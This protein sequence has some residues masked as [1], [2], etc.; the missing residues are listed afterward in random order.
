MVH[1]VEEAVDLRAQLAAGERVVG[2]ATQLDGA[3][4]RAGAAAAST[5]TSH[6]HESGQSWW[7]TPRTIDVVDCP[8]TTVMDPG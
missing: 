4:G 3:A 1:A 7:H 6:A 5:V 2:G 8:S